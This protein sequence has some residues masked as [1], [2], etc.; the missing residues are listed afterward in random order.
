MGRQAAREKLGSLLV[1]ALVGTGKLAQAV[2]DYRIGDFGGQS[3]VVTVSSRGSTH[4]PMTAR[5]RRGSF[6]LQVDVFVA[7]AAGTGWTEADSEDVLD[8]IEAVI[9]SVITDN[10]TSTAWASL[11]YNAPTER[12]D[13]EIGGAEYAH[14]QTVFNV[15][16]YA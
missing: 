6:R 3:P 14:E 9:A 1:T 2:Y 5:G 7:Y 4:P 16:V 11:D 13:V 12:G 8:A 15:E 10:P